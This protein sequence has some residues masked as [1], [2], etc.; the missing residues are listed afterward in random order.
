[1][2]VPLGTGNLLLGFQQG[3][4]D[5]ETCGIIDVDH[6]IQLIGAMPAGD[7]IIEV[8]KRRKN[9]QME[10]PRLPITSQR[11]LM[12]K[13]ATT[14]TPLLPCIDHLVDDLKLMCV[15]VSQNDQLSVAGA[16]L[17]KWE[18]RRILSEPSSMAAFAALPMIRDELNL[19]RHPDQWKV[20]VINSGFGL[21][22]A[23]EQ[24]LVS[25]TLC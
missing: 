23:R 5:C 20:L 16:L 17:G 18:G 19:H 9:P 8:S 7:N 6:P 10:P 4:R 12:P 13:I 21:M 2:I 11:P 15:S 24:R 22:S 3:I 14:Y 25:T 1:V